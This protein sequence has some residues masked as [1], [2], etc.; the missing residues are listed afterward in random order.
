MRQFENPTPT[1]E[2]TQRAAFSV[3][4][5]L[6]PRFCLNK[7]ILKSIMEKKTPEGFELTFIR[8]GQTQDNVTGTLAGHQPGKLTEQG[9][10]Q[11]KQTGKHLKAAKFG[12]AYVSDLGRT[13]HTF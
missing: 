1:G 4:D 8:H 10:K 6:S 12:F 13:K 11:A 5:L 3:L 2:P 9:I 7:L